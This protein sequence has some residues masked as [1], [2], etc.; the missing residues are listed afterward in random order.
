MFLNMGFQDSPLLVT[1]VLRSGRLETLHVPLFFFS[2]V[3][4]QSK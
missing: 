1:R 3:G 2:L 4:D